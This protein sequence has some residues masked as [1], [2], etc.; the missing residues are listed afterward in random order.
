MELVR[1]NEALNERRPHA[2]PDFDVVI[3]TGRAFETM[4]IEKPIGKERI[5]LS[6]NAD[7]A[8]VHDSPSWIT[9]LPAIGK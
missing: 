1:T 6:G 4:K 5:V 8:L 7:S 3:F 2:G 9:S